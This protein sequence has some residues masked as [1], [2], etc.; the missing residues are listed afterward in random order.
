MN[1]K[2]HKVLHCHNSVC[3]ATWTAVLQYC[4]NRDAN[5]AKN[6]LLLLDAWMDGRERPLPFRRDT[7]SPEASGAQYRVRPTMDAEISSGCYLGACFQQQ[8]YRKTGLT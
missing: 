6:L 8:K 1:G 4:S 5:A 2:V 7:V 3:G